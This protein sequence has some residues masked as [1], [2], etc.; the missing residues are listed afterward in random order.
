MKKLII[1]CVLFFGIAPVWKNNTLQLFNVAHADGQVGT[2]QQQ[3]MTSFLWQYTYANN[4]NVVSIMPTQNIGN[5]VTVFGPNYT[6]LAIH[7]FPQMNASSQGFTDFYNNAVNGNNNNDPFDAGN[8]NN[9]P[10]AAS[11]NEQE[12]ADLDNLLMSLQAQREWENQQEYNLFFNEFAFGYE[13]TGSGPSCAQVTYESYTEYTYTEAYTQSSV[14]SSP[15]TAIPGAGLP[16]A[17]KFLLGGKIISFNP[18]QQSGITGVNFTG[19]AIGSIQ[20]SS[21]EYATSIRYDVTTA[22]TYVNSTVVCSGGTG[23]SSTGTFINTK[24]E[25]VFYNPRPY[26]KFVNFDA[27]N[28]LALSALPAGV[29]K[30]GGIDVNTNG[31]IVGYKNLPHDLPGFTIGIDIAN[32]TSAAVNDMV[33]GRKRHGDG[34]FSYYCITLLAEDINTGNNAKKYIPEQINLHL[35]HAVNLPEWARDL[36]NKLFPDI[37]IGQC[38]IDYVNG[39]LDAL[40]Q[41]PSYTSLSSENEKRLAEFKSIAYDLVFGY[42]YCATNEEAAKNQ[43]CGMQ[44]GMGMLHELIAAVDIDQM[45]EGLIKLVQGLGNLIQQNVQNV[46]D[47]VKDASTSE[48]VTGIFDY[49]RFTK[50]ITTKNFQQA[51]S[52][53]YKALLIAD[54]FKK[55]YFTECGAVPM[56]DGVNYDICCYRKGE[57]T[58]MVLPILMTAGDYAVVKLS[59]LAAKYGARAKNAI[60]MIDDATTSGAT[61]IDNV[62]GEIKIIEPGDVGV[63]ELTTT[64]KKEDNIKEVKFDREQNEFEPYPVNVNIPLINGRKPVNHEFH[65]QTYHTKSGYDVPFDNNGFPDMDAFSAR[66]VRINNMDGTVSGDFSKANMQA[67]GVADPNYHLTV[68]N[69]QYANYTWHHHQDTKSMMLVPKAINNPAAGG[70]AHTGGAAIVKHVNNGGNPFNFVSPPLR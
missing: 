19:T 33:V 35:E 40:H 25:N 57:L 61:I 28:S 69:G 30:I 38:T 42:F 31:D 44:V 37:I 36:F 60:R 55:M 16:C 13:N 8:N 62:P 34:T 12:W 23:S 39:K 3:I 45:K 2:Q 27:L 56:D 43:P 22:S 50:F 58:M 20:T 70:V 48:T 32:I 11:N 64:I 10:D 53:Y 54:N 66:T 68:G 14:T 59:A 1:C 51:Q 46:I 7:T 52:L 4:N 47:G 65:G 5:S 15:N 63:D 17:N 29:E 24:N 41:K 21:G 26:I 9:N 49:E 18:T 67:F 6:I